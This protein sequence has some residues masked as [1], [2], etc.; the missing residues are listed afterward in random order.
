VIDQFRSAFNDSLSKAS[1]LWNP[2]LVIP[3]NYISQEIR[4]AQQAALGKLFPPSSMIGALRGTAKHGQISDNSARID[5]Q[6]CIT[7]LAHNPIALVLFELVTVADLEEIERIFRKVAVQENGVK[8]DDIVR[9]IELDGSE[10]SPY[11]DKIYLYTAQGPTDFIEPTLVCALKGSSLANLDK[12]HATAGAIIEEVQK[13]IE[14]R[15]PECMHGF[16]FRNTLHLQNRPNNLPS[17]Y[18]YDANVAAGLRLEQSFEK[19]ENNGRHNYQPYRSSRDIAETLVEL[20]QV[21]DHQGQNRNLLNEIGMYPDCVLGVIDESLLVSSDRKYFQ[22]NDCYFPCNYV[23]MSFSSDFFHD[24]TATTFILQLSNLLHLDALSFKQSIDVDTIDTPEIDFDAEEEI[25]KK[26]RKELYLKIQSIED[27]QDWL[28]NYDWYIVKV[29][30]ENK[31]VFTNEESYR[32]GMIL[33]GIHAYSLSDDFG[34]RVLQNRNITRTAIE[35][36]RKRLAALWE[37]LTVESNLRRGKPKVSNLFR[38]IENRLIKQ[39]ENYAAWI[40]QERIEEWLLNFEDDRERLTALNLLDKLGYVPYAQLKSISTK[41][42]ERILMKLEDITIEDCIFCNIG[43]LTSSSSQIVGLF[44]QENGINKNLFFDYKE[45]DNIKD[46]RVLLLLDDF[47]GSGNTFV[48]WF[49]SSI[50]SDLL[51]KFDK[52]YFCVLTAFD[53]GVTEIKRRTGI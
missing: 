51:E 8:D 15:M 31:H 27:I 32:G 6:E 47:V 13:T 5:P 52:V 21:L 29:L 4:K 19:I 44:Q 23:A 12:K 3:H 45:L 49:T 22:Y 2:S 18:V 24:K 40:P 36:K 17:L 35:R 39:I 1:A 41:L 16:H 10:Y 25:L 48:N 33:P 26:R 7:L 50:G 46:K 43:D 28:N 9:P 11:L 42:Y 37:Y 20:F 34:S 30:Q 14:E 53:K 38:N